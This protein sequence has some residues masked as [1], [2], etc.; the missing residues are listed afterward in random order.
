MIIENIV[1]RVKTKNRGEWLDL[2]SSEF[3]AR[4]EERTYPLRFSI[5]DITDEGIV[6]GKID[7]GALPRPAKARPLLDSPLVEPR[8]WVETETAKI[9]ADVLSLDTVGIHD[10]FFDLGGH[11]LAAT[12]VISRVI[13]RF[14]VVV[15][16]ESL[17]GAPTVAAMAALVV[18]HQSQRTG[19]RELCRLLAELES[20]TETDAARML[21]AEA[22]AGK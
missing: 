19:E 11:S 22:G 18:N 3:A 12:R 16:M 13:S 10:N 21:A 9:W 5:A 20:L 4:L 17:F 8:N 15:P 2:V 1:H 6:I 14:K 7:R